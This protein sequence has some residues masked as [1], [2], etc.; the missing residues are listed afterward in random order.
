MFS[1]GQRWNIGK[2]KTRDLGWSESRPPWRSFI[3]FYLWNP[4]S[5]T[6]FLLFIHLSSLSLSRRNHMTSLTS[7]FLIATAFQLLSPLS[8]SSSFSQLSCSTLNLFFYF[9]WFCGFWLKSLIWCY[10]LGL[11]LL[12]SEVGLSFDG[13]GSVFYG[14][15][16]IVDDHIMVQFWFSVF[17]FTKNT[18]LSIFSTW[19]LRNWACLFHMSSGMVLNWIDNQRVKPPTGVLVINK[20]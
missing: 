13:I 1:Y 18:V 6:K 2:S 12:V 14:F 3:T 8:L 5:Q 4:N 9:S 19:L 20:W 15:W 10:F 11:C 17:P 16:R 7:L